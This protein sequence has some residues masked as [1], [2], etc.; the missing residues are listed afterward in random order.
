MAW[1][2]KTYAIRRTQARTD[3]DWL[4]EK[5]LIEEVRDKSDGRIKRVCRTSEASQ[6]VAKRERRKGPPLSFLKGMPTATP[7]TSCE[8]AACSRSEPEPAEGETQASLHARGTPRRKH[9]GK[10]SCADSGA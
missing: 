10:R 3:L 7:T 9:G 8:A 4:E 5:K 2:K 6:L 1:V